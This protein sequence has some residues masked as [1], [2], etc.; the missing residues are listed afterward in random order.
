MKSFV[1]KYKKYIA[2]YHLKQRFKITI[3]CDDN[4]LSWRKIVQNHAG[5]VP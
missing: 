1:L 2:S 5:P 3:K 4:T